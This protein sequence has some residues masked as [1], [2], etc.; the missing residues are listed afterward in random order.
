METASFSKLVTVQISEVDYVMLNRIAKHDNISIAHA[1]TMQFSGWGAYDGWFEERQ[2][3][4][5]TLADDL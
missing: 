3:D 2:G 1:L 5:V 4:L